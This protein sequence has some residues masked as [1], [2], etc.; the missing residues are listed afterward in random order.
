MITGTLKSKVDSIR[1]EFYNE[2]MTQG[3]EVV[4]QLTMLMFAKMLDDKQ[5]ALEANALMLGVEPKQEDLTF[6]KGN[7]TNYI[8]R[9]GTREI[10]FTIAYDDLRWKNFKHLNSTE[11]AYRIKN[12]VIPFIM[13]PNNKSVG[14]FATYF[15][16]EFSFGFNGRERLL[17]IVVD[18][19]SDDEFNFT[20]TD[21][22]GDLYEYVC[23]SGI[24]GQFR[25]PRHIIDMA[26]EMMKPQIGETIIDPAMGTAGFLTEAAKYIQEHQKIELYNAK[27]KKIFNSDMFYGCDTDDS[28]ARIGYMNAI[29]HGI[30]EPNFSM[31]SLLEAENSEHL[32]E[33][34]DVVLQN[35]P[36]AGALKK[37][38]VNPQLLSVANTKATEVL[39][40]ALMLKLMKVGGRGMSIV[41]E[42]VLFTE[43]ENAYVDLRKELVENHK[44]IGII[45]MPNGIFKA[46]SKKGSSS[47]GA[48][49][50]TSF[51]IFQKTNNGGT[52]FVWFYNMENDGFTLDQ[53]RTPIDESDIEDIICRFNNLD[54]EKDRARTDK[55]FLVPVDEIR[56]NN[57]NLSINKYREV[58]RDPVVYRN[59]KDILIDIQST[60]KA[61]SELI[62]SL[63]TLLK[64]V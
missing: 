5:N 50:K 42:G 8:D 29:L 2:N 12:Y 48:G 27:N 14:K 19:L 59:T 37:E 10:N 44:L 22:M 25:T 36:F 35:P 40:V 55:S 23:G 30:K 13:D 56:A 60:Y 38:V 54:N 31:K 62:K 20:Q 61:E 18:K 63:E 11:L 58:E 57:Y 64:E 21:V 51:L 32:F 16:K 15:N 41:P 33:K 47:K 4:N 34:F 43:S 17:A 24:S 3:N 7:Y 28:M 53:K 52:D 6:K 1:Q 46:A 39:F 9:N 26:V 45:S 49:V